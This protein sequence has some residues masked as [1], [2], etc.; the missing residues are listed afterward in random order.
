MESP[1]ANGL[2]KRA[3]VESGATETM[4]V[5]WMSKEASERVTKLTLDNLGIAEKD[6][7]KLQTVPFFELLEAN[8]AALEQVGNEFKIPAALGEGYSLSWEPYVDGDFI[9]SDVV[10]SNAFP[11]N[12]ENYSLLIGSNLNEWETMGKIAN[13]SQNDVNKDSSLLHAKYG[14]KAS[15]VL[16]AFKQAYPGKAD[17][18]AAYVDAKTIRIPMLKIMR[19]KAKQSAPVY[20]YIFA[21]DSPLAVH[22]AEIPYV[23]SNVEMSTLETTDSGA[24]ERVQNDMSDA[25]IAFAKTGN[26]STKNLVWKPYTNDEGATMLFD[27]ESKL[28]YNHDKNLIQLIAPEYDWK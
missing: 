23:F 5:T 17:F 13:L 11:K 15:D 14:A 22:T 8:Q 16:S 2:F 12:A 25:W 1:Y 3:I 4:G 7:E 21:F 19:A 9:P 24:R 6:F 27:K 18:E 28:V 26:P 20:S 10:S